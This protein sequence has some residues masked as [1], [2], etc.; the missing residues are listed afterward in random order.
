VESGEKVPDYHNI[1]V[2][3]N[4]S[5]SKKAYSPGGTN[6]RDPEGFLSGKQ[7]LSAVSCGDKKKARGI[8]VLE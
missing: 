5:L 8:R 4:L 3:W 7:T 1:N 2:F 6:G